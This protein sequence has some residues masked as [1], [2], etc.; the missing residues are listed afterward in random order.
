M[1]NYFRERIW[2]IYSILAALSWG[3][4]GV[5]SKFISADISPFE[6]H[7]LFTIGILFTLP[8]IIRKCR[9]MELTTKG[10]LW[11][12]LPALLAITGNI[13]V[14]RSFE[15]G[16]KAAVVIPFTNLYPV[17]TILIAVG[18]FREKL[19]WKNGIGISLVLPAI[20]LMSG[21]F[22]ISDH[23]GALCKNGDM[24]I[25]FLFA[26][27]AMMF[28]GLFSA[29]QKVTAGYLSGSWSFLGFIISS[30]IFT[31][32]FLAFGLVDFDFSRTTWCAGTL[33][34]LFD[35]LGVLFIYLAYQAKGKAY[36]VSSI[37]STLQQVFTVVLAILFLKERITLTGFA[38][39]GMAVAGAW[40]LVKDK[41]ISDS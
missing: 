30:V 17:V 37:A 3:A 41:K 39:I 20:V 36:Q 18:I 13:C 16:G 11:G 14:Y 40:F 10:I 27:L 8:F 35:G 15:L 2:L 33:A 7:F 22:G 31:T 26:L 4:W 28:F 24:D 5:L 19:S 9:V 29:S 12:I 38:G 21:H 23:Q 1:I 25:W 32:V 6:N 34:G